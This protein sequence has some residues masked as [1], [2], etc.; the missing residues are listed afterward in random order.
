MID[1]PPLY[2]LR[3]I[4]QKRDDR[5]IPGLFVPTEDKLIVCFHNVMIL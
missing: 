3:Q 2:N 4:T 1:S 5:T